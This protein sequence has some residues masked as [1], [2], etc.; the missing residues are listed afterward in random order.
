M[1]CYK[2]NKLNHRTA[3]ILPGR[4]ME[5]EPRRILLGLEQTSK[6]GLKTTPARGPNFILSAW[7]KNHATS[8]IENNKAIRWQLV[9]ENSGPVISREEDSLKDRTGRDSPRQLC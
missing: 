9:E 7:G 4:I 3:R 6:A 2:N 5:R 8:I 1:R